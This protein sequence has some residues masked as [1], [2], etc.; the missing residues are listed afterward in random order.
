[1]RGCELLRGDGLIVYRG[2]NFIIDWDLIRLVR[3]NSFIVDYCD[4]LKF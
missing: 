3:R 2:N 1:M 4:I